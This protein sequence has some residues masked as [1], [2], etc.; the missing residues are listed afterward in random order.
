MRIKRVRKKILKNITF[1]VLALGSMSQTTAFASPIPVETL[2]ELSAL[3]N[4]SISRDGDYMVGLVGQKG[5]ERHML[6]VWDPRDLS[7][8]PKMTKPDG[9]VEFIYAE[10]LKAGKILVV[11]RTKWTGALAGC[12]EG[13]RIGA[14]KTYLT[15]I[16]ITDTK[17]SSFTEP[18]E[19]SMS[20][21]DM[22]EAERI[23]SEIIGTGQIEADLPLDPEN[24]IIANRSGVFDRSTSY[25]KFN[26][27]T[28]KGESLFKNRGRQS[29]GLMD[30]RTGEV[31]TKGEGDYTDG[32]YKSV[33]LIKSDAGE[34]EK[35]DKLTSDSND[36][37][38][39]NILGRNE[40]SGKYY[41]ATDQFS[42]NMRIYEYDASAK[43]YNSAPKFQNNQFD[44]TSIVRST[45]AATF[46]KILGH[47]YAGGSSGAVWSDPNFAKIQRSFEQKFAGK[48]VTIT[49]WTQN[50]DKLIVQVDGDDTPTSYFLYS[51][52]GAKFL[53]SAVP[54]L[55]KN[56]LQPGKLVYYT[57]RDGMKVPGLLTMPVG[58]K[59]GDVAPPAV[60]HPHGGPWARDS[61]G[62]DST[63]W[64]PFLTSRGYA[65]LRPQYRGSTGWGRKLWLAGD[66][67]W[68]QKMQDDKDDGAAWMVKQGFADPD[69]IA[70]FGYSYG[71]YA[72]FAAAVRPDSPYAC[73][74]GGAGVSAL[75]KLGRT[76]SSSRLQRAYQ[77]KTVKGMDP[78][79]NTDK[80]NIPVLVIHGDR[81][82]RVPMFH[83]KDYYKKVKR[84]VP[85]KMVVIKDM[86][87]SLPWT[88]KMQ[89]QKLSAIEDFLKN[90]CFDKS[91]VNI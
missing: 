90:D 48:N 28:N 44:V 7:K 69:K 78:M 32:R 70:I 26:L 91:Q 22:S 16:F 61:I 49:D 60:I 19:G 65:V 52:G 15:K 1:A 84:K 37:H 68:G 88:P 31:L 45:K 85:A 2:S 51:G 76:W 83:G 71:G 10:A 25:I 55:A 86:P 89:K 20:N 75:T 42:D 53:G 73:A 9:D 34:F 21:R 66:A 80:A 72:A 82:V 54:K 59:P 47:R 56:E 63:G 87:H 38:N 14:T 29:I 81:D 30:P 27:K 12:G 11:A 3:T 35:H 36:R 62:W 18:F 79:L 6:A 24:I 23:C 5:S 40:T 50:E 57:A 8:A 17:F 58:W 13:K 46:G 74:I 67:E 77:G 4:I 64:V 33:T 43:A 41:I 39:V